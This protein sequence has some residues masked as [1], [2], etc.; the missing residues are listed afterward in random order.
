MRRATESLDRR[1]AEVV[2]RLLLIAEDLLECALSGE[3]DLKGFARDFLKRRKVN[4]VL[5]IPAW[6]LA[7]AIRRPTPSRPHPVPVTRKE[8]ATLLVRLVQDCGGNREDGLT[9]APNPEFLREVEATLARLPADLF[10]EEGH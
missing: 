6:E 1:V 2:H 7:D 9:I 8:A 3:E 5:R 4:A 10:D